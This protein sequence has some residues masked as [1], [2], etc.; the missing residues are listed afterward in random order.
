MAVLA[1]VIWPFAFAP[2]GWWPLSIVSLM[3]LFLLWR[4]ASA[5]A[6]LRRGYLFGLGAF[7]VGVSWVYISMH[8]YGGMEPL[9]AGGVTA[10]LAAWMALFPALAGW[11]A[12]GL[13]GKHAR[14]AWVA[15]FPAA[16]MLFEWVR[17][18]L[19]TGF[20]W[21]HLGYSQIDAPLAGYAPLIGV[22]G[23]SLIGAL[24]AALL[25]FAFTAAGRGRYVALA[26]CA[27]LWIS[28]A[29]L[30]FVDWTRSAG[31]PMRVSLVQGNVS[32][33]LKWDPA[34]REVTVELYAKLTRE[35]WDSDLII[36]PETAM[37]MYYAEA[38]SYLDVLA[39]EAIKHGATLLVGLVYLDP[40]AR[41]YYN[42]MIDAAQ[43]ESLYH[44]RHLVPFTEYLP[45]QSVLGGLID[46]FEIPM[47]NFSAGANAQPP[48]E[49][50]GQL[51][52]ISICFEDAFGEEIIR[53]LPT[54]TVLVNVSN[55]AWF[56]DSAA[57]HQ[58][59]QIARM[60]A[61]ETG[62]YM[63]R[64]TNTGMTAFIGPRGELRSVA[65]QFKTTVLTDE[66][67]PRTDATPYVI[68]GNAVAVAMAL[69]LLLAGV[70]ADR[71]RAPH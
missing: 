25:L 65:P 55:D 23:V 29:A 71:K 33:D 1:G 41:R 40:A 47:S 45:A 58:H 57:P 10:L 24:S 30:G 27:A 17:G 20:P 6:A 62:R 9:L 67:E 48:I 49:V 39:E 13:T 15:S 34:M 70:F 46:T 51:L 32:Q 56:N 52:G 19:L 3:L 66:I 50:A 38:R 36:W 68:V 18:W 64:A 5:G 43:N 7:G 35:H 60:R 63:A 14:H 28:G 44:K 31:A 11:I 8:D 53:D 26:L 37:P 2:W 12:V 16:W 21:L 61:L 42:S 59:L 4:S 69:V 22:Y 54:A